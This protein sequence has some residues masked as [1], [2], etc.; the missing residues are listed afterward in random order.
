[1][2]FT[3]RAQQGDDCNES[4]C[5][6]DR[7]EDLAPNHSRTSQCPFPSTEI[8]GTKSS[9][10]CPSLERRA[11]GVVQS[12]SILRPC[13]AGKQDV[14]HYRNCQNQYRSFRYL[15]D[16]SWLHVAANHVTVVLVGD[17]RSRF[18]VGVIG[19]TFSASAHEETHLKEHIGDQI[20]GDTRSP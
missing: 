5:L 19:S 8:A 15:H 3:H 20:F 13:Q 12:R 18:F 14:E 17:E 11:F 6:I 2:R 7:L 4:D 9:Q 1:M 16:Y 10:L